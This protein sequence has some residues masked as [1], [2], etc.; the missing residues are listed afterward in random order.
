MGV[1][2]CKGEHDAPDGQ[3]AAVDP[4]PCARRAQV[5]VVG[6]REVD[7]E[8]AAER[9][10]DHCAVAEHPPLERERE[11]AVAVGARGGRR[12]RRWLLLWM[13]VVGVGVG[14]V[15]LL[16]MMVRRRRCC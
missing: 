15:R 14:G 1:A 2:V 11:Y 12:G 5:E 4:P 6:A 10:G 16:L 9:R 8:E 3:H 13:R 7:E